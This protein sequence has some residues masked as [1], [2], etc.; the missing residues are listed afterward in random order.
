MSDKKVIREE[1]FKDN[2]IKRTNRIEGQI[3][4]IKNM[5]TDDK[6]CDDILHQIIAVKSALDSV[7]KLLLK[8]HMHHCLVHDI[9]NNK[10]ETMEELL[11]TIGKLIK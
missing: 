6:Y 11:V 10:D 1:E 3:R 4:G 5:I 8:D 9:K 7:S 2:L